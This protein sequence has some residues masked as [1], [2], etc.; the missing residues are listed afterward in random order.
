MDTTQQTGRTSH[1]RYYIKGCWGISS[2]KVVSTTTTRDYPSLFGEAL[3]G[4]V[5]Y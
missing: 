1:T 3:Q 2:T 4:L 5:H